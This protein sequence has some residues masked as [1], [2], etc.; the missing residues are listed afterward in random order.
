LRYED[1]RDEHGEAHEEQRYGT[2]P[3]F[4]G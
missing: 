1:N 4:N 3:D 2:F